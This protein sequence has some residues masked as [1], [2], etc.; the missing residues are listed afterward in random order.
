MLKYAVLTW[1]CQMNERDSEILA[2]ILEALGYREAEDPRDADVVLLNS[3]CV[4]ASAERKVLAKLREVL[5]WKRRRPEM[6]V[7]LCGCLPRRP[8][9]AEELKKWRG[10]DLLVGPGNLGDLPALL[11][12]C[13]RE[14]VPVVAL[15]PEERLTEGLPQLRRHPWKAWVTI[16]RG[17]DN[18]CSYCVVPHVRGRHQSRDP[19]AIIQEVQDLVKRGYREVCLLGQNVNA[20]GRDLEPGVDFSW[21][22]RRLDRI[23]GLLR[24]RYTTSHPRDFSPEMVETIAS[25]HKV[26]EHFHLPLQSGSDRILRLMNRGYTQEQYIRLC[27]IIRREVPGASITTDI[28]VG[29]PGETEDDFRE[30]LYVVR[31]VQFE[32]AFTFMYSPRPGTRAAAMQHQLPREVKLARLQELIAVQ[33]EITER[34]NQALVG[35]VVE[36]I[37]DG[38]SRKDPHLLQGR[39]RTDKVVV[40]AGKLE[41]V[42]HPVS[43]LIRQAGTWALRGTLWEGVGG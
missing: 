43:V 17:C 4:R 30:T 39:T 28:M 15:D 7:G 27:E 13:R 8:G 33:K 26:C 24:I 21:L 16:T 41:M 23:D 38:P 2:G 37:P 5:G 34:R 29:F 20:Y 1:G 22:L 31:T 6:I 3:C 36:V 19:Q 18:W 12:R 14:D 25:C 40:F 32:A 35:S 9:G 10:L 11:E 42:G